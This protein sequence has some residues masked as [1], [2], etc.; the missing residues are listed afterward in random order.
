VAIGARIIHQPLGETALCGEI[1]GKDAAKAR[2][3]DNC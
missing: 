3:Y 1:T 2:H